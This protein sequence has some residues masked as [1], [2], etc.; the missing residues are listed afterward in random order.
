MYIKHLQ[1]SL[2]EKTVKPN[3]PIKII[4]GIGNE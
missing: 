1:I 3:N 2:L 4:N